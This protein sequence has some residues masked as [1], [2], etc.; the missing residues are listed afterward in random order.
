MND[1]DK[2]HKKKEKYANLND[3]VEYEEIEKKMKRRKVE[4]KFTNTN[5]MEYKLNI[6]NNIFLK[7]MK[8]NK[9][10]YEKIDN[11]E[12]IY[13]K[14]KADIIS[15]NI[16]YVQMEHYDSFFYYEKNKIDFI[17]PELD[18]IINS[19]NIDT[20]KD[21]CDISF[22][23]IYNPTLGK[24]I[25]EW[26][27]KDR[28]NNDK[29]EYTESVNMSY[30]FSLNILL[31]YLIYKNDDNSNY[32]CMI[33]LNMLHWMHNDKKIL[34]FRLFILKGILKR[35]LFCCS[36][37]NDKEILKLKKIEN[38]SVID[39]EK[40]DVLKNIFLT[41][42]NSVEY[43]D[44]SNL[45]NINDKNCIFELIKFFI[46]LIKRPLI[47]S[48]HILCVNY[49]IKIVKSCYDFRFTYNIN[50]ELYDIGP[51]VN[52]FVK[53]INLILAKIL[54]VIKDT[55]NDENM[56][57]LEQINNIN[58]LIT[59]FFI[60]ILN[61]C[62]RIIIPQV[63]INDKLKKQY[64][65]NNE[66]KY[67]REAN[68]NNDDK[69][70]ED[71][72]VVN[73]CNPI[74]S[75]I[76]IFIINHSDKYEKNVFI[77]LIKILIKEC[78]KIEKRYNIMKMIS[79]EYILFIKDGDSKRKHDKS[80]DTNYIKNRKVSRKRFDSNASFKLSDEY[81]SSIYSETEDEDK[82]E[83]DV[84]K[85]GIRNIT[86][87]QNGINV[88]DGD[89]NN[90]RNNEINE[91]TNE[92][93]M[94]ESTKINKD[95]IIS[96]QGEEQIKSN[97]SPEAIDDLNEIN[98]QPKKKVYRNNFI[99]KLNYKRKG[100][101]HIDNKR[102]YITYESV[103]VR[104]LNLLLKYMNCERYQIR[105]TML[106]LFL[107]LIKKK[108]TNKNESI[109]QSIFKLFLERLEDPNVIVK[110]KALS[111]LVTLT[112]KKYYDNSLIYKFIFNKMNEKINMY[113]I[114]S[115]NIYSNR[116][117]IRK[118]IIQY[119]EAIFETL[120]HKKLNYKI[121]FFFVCNYLCTLSL[122]A[123]SSVR[124]QVLLTVNNLFINASHD[125]HITKIWIA[126]IF[127]AITDIEETI[128]DECVSIFLNTFI[129]PAF[130]SSLLNINENKIKQVL[131]KYNITYFKINQELVEKISMKYLNENPRKYEC[132]DMPNKVPIISLSD[133]T[134]NNK[135]K[136]ENNID[137][138]N[139]EGKIYEDNNYS[140]INMDKI[141]EEKKNKNLKKQSDEEYDRNNDGILYLIH[142][143][144]IYFENDFNNTFICILKYMTKYDLLHFNIIISYLKK[145]KNNTLEE[146]I[147][148]LN[149]FLYNMRYFSIKVLN[150][151]LL[152][153]IIQL[154]KEYQ[155]KI[156][157]ENV[158]FL[159]NR[160]YEIYLMNINNMNSGSNI[161][162]Y[163]NKYKTNHLEKK[164]NNDHS[165][166]NISNVVLNDNIEEKENNIL[167][168][169]ILSNE[170]LIY[171]KEIC[172]NGI[173]KNILLKLFTI[174]YNLLDTTEEE[175]D[176]S[177]LVKMENT[178]YHFNCPIC[179]IY[180]ILNII[181]K[182]KKN[183]NEF[184]EK[185]KNKIVYFFEHI[186]SIELNNIFCNILITFIFLIND[187][188]KGDTFLNMVCIKLKRIYENID[189]T[190][191][192][193]TSN[194]NN[195]NNNNNISGSDNNNNNIIFGSNNSSCNNNIMIKN[196]IYLTQSILVIDKSVS[197]R[198]DLF[199][200]FEKDL[201]NVNTCMNILN[202]LIILIYYMIINFGSSCNK[203]VFV[204]LRFF[205][206]DNSFLRYL[207]FYVLSKLLSEDYIKYNNQFFFGVL[208]LLADKNEIIRKQSLS[209]FKHILMMYSNKTNI[210]NYIIECI[211]VLN[212]FYNFKLSKHLIHI[213][214]IFHI[215]NKIDRYK[216]YSY[217]LENLSNSEKF[218]LQQK[219]INEY[220]I[221]YV[222]NYDNYYFEEDDDIRNENSKLKKKTILPL[223]DEDN[224]GSVLLDVLNIL[225]CKL[226]K[227][228]IKKD[229]APK[230]E[231]KNK[232]IRIKNVENS[233]KVLNDLMKNIL[234]K[235][236]L[237]I[238]LSLR[239]IMFK[240]KSFFFKYI[241]NLIIYLCIDYKDSIEELINET[242]I[243]N[244]IIIDFQNFIYVDSI[245]LHAEQYNHL[246]FDKNKNININFLEH[247][248]NIFDTQINHHQNKAKKNKRN[249]KYYHLMD[250][251]HNNNNDKKN[252][253][254]YS[255]YTSSDEYQQVEKVLH[256]ISS[257]SDE[258]AQK[259]K[260][261]KNNK[262]K[263]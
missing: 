230:L 5:T 213:G 196:C 221:Q 59:L 28:N 165:N 178:I 209:V 215:H 219:L 49:L 123:M 80:I 97:E 13:R 250:N 18:N 144:N 55:K 125:F 254:N 160:C 122:D 103:M 118:V 62:V 93:T 44:I 145:K 164:D 232:N 73:A 112:N 60:N 177:F 206:H 51:E 111:M 187:F 9:E 246:F 16:S 53:I 47:Y 92:I 189:N 41:L 54:S 183:I 140:N 39:E 86:N 181:R 81:S 231:E 224:E 107:S 78:R 114:I 82:N 242:H 136:N 70:F 194:N 126:I 58:N 214:N 260:K 32:S 176:E 4:K 156:K 138:N 166:D 35:F 223:N 233:V 19:S 158:L 161:E 8:E 75:F 101:F 108:R 201:K 79:D 46:E 210:I 208:Y 240:T 253:N 244:E 159:L 238:L 11:V 220:L 110:A 72:V 106:D 37:F 52:I 167:I 182:K 130:S 141:M 193:T 236:T 83:D 69:I 6:H 102:Y 99:N 29:K 249:K 217:L 170:D 185:L 85:N 109:F 155:K 188:K 163:N 198:N 237:P 134:K 27:T 173:L 24:R 247:S 65:L 15:L 245:L 179:F 31:S 225:S 190:E 89:D 48:L 216:I 255:Y 203:F 139:E 137:Y 2:L 25:I 152:D 154:S 12:K 67:N 175:L 23:P 241:N 235:N 174:L 133:D 128:K 17:L 256:G 71:E 131:K 26:L 251:N 205:K 40:L 197:I 127:S 132:S 218:S 229:F 195:N 96:S 50:V 43:I 34:K 168:D 211:F 20:L 116:S 38:D 77:E 202:N 1:K 14:L 148:F 222:Y 98:K 261:K 100:T 262:I 149:S 3:D 33:Y 115:S 234:K 239:T 259:K 57:C 192:N 104:Y 36:Y 162:L 191:M 207:S 226:M 7:H 169:Y 172:T 76:E 105:N 151:F 91:E 180:I 184:I 42:H 56:F 263:K 150:T 228:K 212:N 117:N 142:L 204:L 243:R 88:N 135:F 90:K 146:F 200:N 153:F 74:F 64:L 248:E 30:L 119:I 147:H 66:N 94:K 227:I 120:I 129:K 252:N 199:L 143:C 186:E 45:L 87:N 22:Y 121:F 95:D 113:K 258:Y 84:H 63:L 124:R 61:N 171:E 68:T 10:K 21:L 157:F 257:D